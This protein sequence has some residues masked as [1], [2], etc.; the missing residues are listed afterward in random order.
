MSQT[1]QLANLSNEYVIR[2]MSKRIKNTWLVGSGR[3]EGRLLL[4]TVGKERIWLA[5]GAE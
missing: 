2:R 1:S 5:P 4:V 3:Y